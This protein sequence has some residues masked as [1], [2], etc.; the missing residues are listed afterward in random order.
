MKNDYHNA[1]AF[2]K[3][4]YL[5]IDST[6]LLTSDGIYSKDYL[7]EKI[8]TDDYKKLSSYLEKAL[9]ICD[10]DFVN[11][12]ATGGSVNSV[13]VKSYFE[14]LKDISKSNKYL[15]KIFKAKADFANV[16]IA[17]RIRKYD[18]AKLMFVLGGTLT[19]FELKILCEEQFDT[20]KEYFKFNENSDEIIEAI[21]GLEQNL[22]L[23]NFEKMSESFAVNY[24]LK[25]RYET[26]NIL[27]FIQYVYF[28]LADLSN[29]RIVLFGLINKL[30]KNEIKE[31]LRAY[32]EG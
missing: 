29:T 3:E 25:F 8:M 22:P 2:I 16:S 28:K 23:S 10:Y 30:E 15:M 7:K 12:K 20:L 17:L 14:E 18:E 11:G 5:K 26:Q 9:S 19:D 1:E 24:L 32:Y 6:A 21:K 4:K 27:P 13:F 31:K